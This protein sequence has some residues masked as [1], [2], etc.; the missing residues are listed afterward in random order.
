MP[1][2]GQRLGVS[3]PFRPGISAVGVRPP[4]ATKAL[5]VLSMIP[6][7]LYDFWVSTKSPLAAEVLGRVRELYAIETEIRGH[8]AEHRRRVRDERSRP[9][10]DA[11]Q[12]WLHQHI[13]RVSVVSDLAKA[14]RYAIRHWPGLRGGR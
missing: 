8:P 1:P 14:M 9:I 4:Y 7:R 12:S 2:A 6:D 11:L 5:S 13:D 3:Q 10:I